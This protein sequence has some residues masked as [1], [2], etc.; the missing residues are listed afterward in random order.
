[1]A[2]IEHKMGLKGSA[3]AVINFGEENNCRGFLLGNPPDENGKAEGMAQMFQMMNEERLVTGH[4]ALSTAAVAYY[5]AATYASERI[6]GRPLVNPKGDRVTIINH[7]DV[8]RM[9]MYQKA[10]I[11]ASRAMSI[12][13][14]YLIDIAE[15]SSDPELVKKAKATVEVHTPI[16][17]AYCS[18]VCWLSISEAMQVY[19]GYGFIE[20]YPIAQL[21]RDSRIYSIWE[22]TN[23]I[24]AMDLVGRKWM[25]G[26][27]QVFAAWL[28]DIQ[29]FIDKN[30]DSS[31]AHEL[32][33]LQQAL[34][35]YREIQTTLGGYLGAGKIGMIGLSATRIL[36]ATGKLLGARLLLEQAL[37]AEKQMQELGA[38]HYD[39]GFYQGKVMTAK[40]FA[41]NILPEVSFVLTV[42]K[43]GDTSA[44]DIEQSAFFA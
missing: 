20:E 37:I 6:Q 28:Q 38:D 26:K 24:Q 32:N 35:D 11:E 30:K 29:D 19:G 15:N 18:D 25:M 42:I 9:L 31:F 10:H 40:F 17:K 14:Y 16:V 22:G 8:R 27:G 44:L 2:G 5:N 33:V 13:T 21:L 41:R 1:C 4:A 36:H 39:Y 34:N 23:Y 7:A 43:D 3:T 12:F